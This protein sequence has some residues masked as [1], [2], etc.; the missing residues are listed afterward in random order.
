[1]SSPQVNDIHDLSLEK[2]KEILQ[3]RVAYMQTVI[4]DMKQ[5]SGYM[6]M[7]RDLNGAKE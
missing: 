4:E 3:S 6:K 5:V 7:R 2:S 1:M